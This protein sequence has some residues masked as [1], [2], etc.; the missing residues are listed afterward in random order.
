VDDQNRLLCHP[1]TEA[2]DLRGWSLE[3]LAYRIRRRTG[4]ACRR[5]LVWRWEHEVVPRAYAQQ[6]IAA[7]LGIP[8]ERRKALRWPHWLTTDGP[9][10]LATLPWT[11]DTALH[12]ARNVVTSADVDRRGFLVYVGFGIAQLSGRWIS[13]PAGSADGLI[14]DLTAGNN[15]ILDALQQRL[16]QLWLLD[17][18]LGG[19]PCL[20]AGLGEIR[21]VAHLLRNDRAAAAVAPMW[22]HLAALCRF[23]GW[24][25]FDTNRHALSQRLWHAGLRAAH[26]AGDHG[27]GVYLLSNFALQAIYE[28]QPQAALDALA[29]ARRRTD[30]AHCTVLAMLDCWTARAHAANGDARR[31]AASLNQADGLYLNRTAGSDPDWVYWL[32]QPSLTAE[33]GTTLLDNRDYNAALRCLTDGLASLPDDSARERPIYQIRLAELHLDTGHREQADPVYTEALAGARLLNS[34]RIDQQL[35]PLTRR[36][37]ETGD[38]PEVKTWQVHAMGRRQSHPAAGK[39]RVGR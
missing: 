4:T 26:T 39:G 23:A 36:L 16:Q 1:L 27:Q 18:I 12:I 37:T 15:R 20:E 13:E 30:S 17:D 5:E 11:A 9:V 25:A 19:G 24:A 2:R 35:A 33:A 6:A 8:E 29:V 22:S 10:E 21:L 38:R 28:R 31:A 34:P 3:E 32:P 7:E 14:R